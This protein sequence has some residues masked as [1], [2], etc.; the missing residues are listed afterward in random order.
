MHS[1]SY[2]G[3]SGMSGKSGKSGGMSGKSFE[4]SQS[5]RSYIY[6]GSG[7]KSRISGGSQKIDMVAFME[8]VKEFT[9]PYD[10]L[11]PTQFIAFGATNAQNALI[12]NSLINNLKKCFAMYES[13]TQNHKTLELDNQ[14][15]RMKNEIELK[16]PDR[17]LLWPTFKKF[18][19]DE[20]R[21]MVQ[22]VLTN[23]KSKANN[24]Q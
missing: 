18:I 23:E 21:F 14:L 16:S 11:H 4:S 5:G 24:N 2:N 9:K 22:M 1:H 10:N 17:H 13:N 3:M 19:L 15:F 6:G 12:D 7:R 8:V 20:F